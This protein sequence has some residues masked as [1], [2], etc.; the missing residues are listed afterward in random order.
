MALNGPR[1]S[2]RSTKG[3][4][5]FGFE[6]GQ[7]ET[8]FSFGDTNASAKFFR[9]FLLKCEKYSHLLRPWATICLQFFVF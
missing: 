4:T 2:K 5:F 8:C 7:R 6:G 3:E 9:S 1:P